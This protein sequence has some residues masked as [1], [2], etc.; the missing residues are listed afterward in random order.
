ML[1][2]P[3]HH[4]RRPPHPPQRHRLPRAVPRA[5]RRWQL[6]ARGNREQRLRR[7][8]RRQR[9]RR[10]APREAPTMRTPP[11]P[12]R[13]QLGTRPPDR[14]RVGERLMRTGASRVALAPPS[15]MRGAGPIQDHCYGC[16]LPSC[17]QQR[18]RRQRK[19]QRTACIALDRHLSCGVDGDSQYGDRG[20]H[21]PHRRRRGRCISATRRAVQFHRLLRVGRGEEQT[22]RGQSVRRIAVGLAIAIPGSVYGG[23]LYVSDRPGRRLSVEADRDHAVERLW[24]ADGIHGWDRSDRPGRVQRR[25]AGVWGVHPGVQPRE[26]LAAGHALAVTGRCDGGQRSL[27]GLVGHQ[28]ARRGEDGLPDQSPRRDSRS[29]RSSTTR[30]SCRT[31]PT[32]AGG[33]GSPIGTAGPRRCIRTGLRSTLRPRARWTRTTGESSSGVSRR[34]AHGQGRCSL[35]RPPFRG[36]VLS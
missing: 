5:R 4:L 21:D 33:S 34:F 18:T 6:R 19:R 9:H 2:R 22:M 8:M 24:F 15:R 1:L 7:R 10:D 30:A 16:E 12:D 23:A 31:S 20:I 35:E 11:E 25:L 27:V 3:L 26:H 17:V 32:G 36:H 28:C 29:R 14:K 13:P